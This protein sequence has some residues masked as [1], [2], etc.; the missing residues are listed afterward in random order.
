MKNLILF[1]CLFCGFVACQGQEGQAHKNSK[2]TTEK[3]PHE[4]WTVHENYDENGNLISRDSTYSYS[5]AAVNG[6]EIPAEKMDSLFNQMH[7][8]FSNIHGMDLQDFMQNFKGM[9]FDELLQD[10]PDDFF[11]AP[12]FDDSL[13]TDHQ[14]LHQQLREKMKHFQEQFFQQSSPRS[15][16]RENPDQETQSTKKDTNLKKV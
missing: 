7:S 16:P 2:T 12:F 4:N 14:N 10:I 15:I 13:G 9:D 1:G 3:S 5:Y 8:Q 11:S 6:Q